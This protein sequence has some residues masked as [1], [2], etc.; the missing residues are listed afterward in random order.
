MLQM[1]AFVHFKENRK[2]RIALFIVLLLV[3]V[4][5]IVYWGGKKENLYWDE[6]FTLERAH[7]ISDSTPLEHYIDVDEDYRIGEWLPVSLVYDSLTVDKEESVL[8]DS[9]KSVLG[10][11]FGYHNYSIFLNML[12]AVLSP[13]KLSIWPSIIL[14]IIFFIINQILLYCLCRRMSDNVAFPYAA[15]AW[16]GFTSMCVSMTVFIRFYM[17]ATMLTTL[18]TLMHL[19]YYQTEEKRHLKRL[20]LLGIAF[21]TLYFGYKN[22]QFMLIYAAF[23][24]L[25]FSVVLLVKKGIKS[26]LLYSVPIYGGGI[27]YLATKTEYVRVITDFDKLLANSNGAL[28]W[29]LEQIA[30]FRIDMLPSRIDDMKLILGRYLFGSYYLMIAFLVIT[31]IMIAVRR[32]LLKDKAVVTNSNGFVAALSTA[33]IL[34]MLFFTV[35]GLYEQVRYISFVFTMLTVMLAILSFNISGNSRGKYLGTLLILLLVFLSVNMKGKVDMLYSGDRET[36]E[37]VKNIDSDSFLLHAGGHRTA[38]SYQVALLADPQ[39]EFYV[40]DGDMEGAFDTLESQLRDEMILV[41]RSGV[42]ADDVIDFL[43]QKGYTVDWVGDLYHFVLWDAK[44]P[45]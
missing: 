43:N 28:G 3:Q 10:K 5:N 15:V 36:I 19:I 13:G 41:S 25:S 14:N 17:F 31:V 29:C 20:F 39:D 7:Y 9:P 16:Y 2:L 23:F 42:P 21:S 24:I 4:V 40:Y 34:F 44:I 45:N 18:F 1:N 12:E 33:S 38:I 11:I 6:Y 30:G 35:F 26:F 32:F 8:M 37:R 22:A 27:L